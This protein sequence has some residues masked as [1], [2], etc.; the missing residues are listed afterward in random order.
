MGVG[1]ERKK[2]WGGNVVARF[3]THTSQYCHSNKS[4]GRLSELSGS[5]YCNSDS[6]LISSAKMNKKKNLCTTTLVYPRV[7]YSG[8]EYL[9]LT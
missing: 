8:H 3:L 9:S 5:T 1:E 6:C 7:L 2:S 4:W